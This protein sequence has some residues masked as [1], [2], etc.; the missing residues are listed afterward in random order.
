MKADRLYHLWS[1]SQRSQINL[2]W[3]GS[4]QKLA[5]S[6]TSARALYKP[7]K[8]CC[9]WGFSVSQTFLWVLST[10]SFGHFKFIIVYGRNIFMFSSRILR[11]AICFSWK[12]QL[13]HF[14]VK[15]LPPW[16]AAG[17]QPSLSPAG[18]ALTDPVSHPGTWNTIPSTPRCL[19][20][21]G[22][23]CSKP[24]SLPKGEKQFPKAA[25]R[26]ELAEVAA[27][28]KLSGKGLW[29]EG[30]AHMGS[31]L[32][33]LQGAAQNLTPASLPS[34]TTGPGDSSPCHLFLSL[35]Y[36]FDFRC[37]RAQPSEH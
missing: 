26:R 30:A 33:W 9:L 32:H 21:L 19:Q 36:D 22:A 1:Q 16:E 15:T 6:F 11:G 12:T 31:P 34:S 7:V 4:A 20:E 27:A 5:S 17:R 28:Q 35:S 13:W 18:A 14:W 8:C 3:W 24:F 23:A 10:F 2:D 25:S 29:P 37:L